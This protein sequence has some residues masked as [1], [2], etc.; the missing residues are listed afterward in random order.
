MDA[1][2]RMAVTT[3][4]LK[5]LDLNCTCVKGVRCH[6]LFVDGFVVCVVVAGREPASKDAVDFQ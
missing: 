3:P 4:A 5:A 6:W 2:V 1:V